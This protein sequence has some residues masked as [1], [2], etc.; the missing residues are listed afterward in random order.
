[1]NYSLSNIQFKN[2]LIAS[3]SPL[4]E[5]VERLECCR[6]AGFSAAILKSCAD[7]L[8]S[9]NG[10]GRKVVYTEDGYYADASFENEILTLNEGIS[11]FTSAKAKMENEM[12]L[13]PSVSAASLKATDWLPICRAFE[14][15][16]ASI[17]QLDFFYLGTIEHT[18]QFYTKLGD[19]LETLTATLS[20][21][22]M[23]KIN[24]R[25]D[26]ER[27][28]SLFKNSGIKVVSVLDS[29]REV[30]PKH[31]NLHDD[32]TSYFGPRQ[33]P[34]TIEYLKTA[35]KYGLDVCAGGG[36][37]KKADIDALLSLGADMIQVAS[38]VLNRNYTCVRDLLP[39]TNIPNDSP[40][41]T[42]NPWCDYVSRGHCDQCGACIKHPLP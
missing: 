13:I 15:V 27:T 28:F 31:F 21:I 8:R 7:Y 1:M 37:S 4:T 16:G 25:F 3:S 38:Y 26:A 42:H 11:L 29:M 9:G 22:I 2:Y 6:E 12:L 33:F 20:C 18:D 19:L 23:P 10:Y 32:T 39:E 5:S 36:V 24:I 35:K 40:L 41:L 17:L 30:P 14:A 34:Y